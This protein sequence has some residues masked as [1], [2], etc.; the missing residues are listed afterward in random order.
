MNK[1]IYIAILAFF[2]SC[3]KQ[4]DPTD[5]LKYKS[6]SPSETE[7]YIDLYVNNF[8]SLENDPVTINEVLIEGD[9]LIVNLSYSGGCAE[10]EFNL[11]RI[12]PSCGTP[13]LPPPTFE[14]KHNAN[15]D[16]CEA[17]LTDTLAFDISRLRNSED[18]QMTISFSA[19]EYN[20]E[21]F[22]FNLNYRYE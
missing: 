4:E 3:E 6:I 8:D 21:Y 5:G 12:H 11:A 1:L 14:L 9:L 7:E 2:M 17:W 10:H 15:G 20:D 18:S 16:L 13:P 19:N 22:H